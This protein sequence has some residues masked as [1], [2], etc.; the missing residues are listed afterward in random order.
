MSVQKIITRF[1]PS[2]SGLLHLGHAYSALFAAKEAKDNDGTFI[3]R[4]EDIDLERCDRQYEQHIEE[5]LSWLDIYWHDKP[6]R[7]SEH[8]PEYS[9]ALK[10]LEALGLIYPCFL[11]RKEL[12]AALSAPHDK[13]NKN[14]NSPPVLNTDQYISNLERERRITKEE[15]F[16]LRLRMTAALKLVGTLHWRDIEFGTHVAKPEIFGD[17]VI[18]R[19]DIPT[20]YHLSV[21]VDDAI[22]GVTTVTRGNDLFS[23]THLHRLLQELLNLPVPVYRHH[24]VLTSENGKRLAKRDK[25]VTLQSLRESGAKPRDILTMLGFVW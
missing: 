20:S 6:R 19:K 5:D 10:K 11:S 1:A 3:L 2:P 17:V 22:Q 7:Q 15:P 8:F 23:A 25:S 4:F 21:V 13:P 24:K 9:T 18:A 16:A 14:N 12:K